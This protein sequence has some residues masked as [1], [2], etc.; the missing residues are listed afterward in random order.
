MRKDMKRV[1]IT[2]P[3]HGSK[4]KNEDVKDQRRRA[5]DNSEYDNLPQKSSMKPKGKHS[6]F[7]KELSDFLNPLVGFLR[8]NCGRPWDKIYSEISENLDRRGV[9]NAHI[10][11]HLDQMVVTKPMWIDNRPHETGSWDGPQPLYKSRGN[12]GSFYVD[13][14]GILREPKEPRPKNQYKTNPNIIKEDDRTYICN[15]EGCWFEL[16]P[17]SDNHFGRLHRPPQWVQELF[18]HEGLRYDWGILRS[19]S[20]K[21]KTDLL[22][23]NK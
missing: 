7:R 15:P 9:I 5:R 8:K 10:F 22:S 13:R 11:Q 1:I 6:W 20:K 2:R 4:F 3:R 23:R 18:P 21:E 16:A 12:W 19:L 14:H 17:L